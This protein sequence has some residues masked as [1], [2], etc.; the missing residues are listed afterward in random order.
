MPAC[1]GLLLSAPHPLWWSQSPSAA[2]RTS[3]ATCAYCVLSA[4]LAQ[5]CSVVAVDS[6]VCFPRRRALM[7]LSL[8]HVRAGA[9]GPPRRAVAGP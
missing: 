2:I 7:N 4:A 1:Q 3:Q 8:P 6:T 5:V 9:A